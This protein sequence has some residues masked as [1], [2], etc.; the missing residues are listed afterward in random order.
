MKQWFYVFSIIVLALFAMGE[1]EMCKHSLKCNMVHIYEETPNAANT[2]GEMF[3]QGLYYGR[4]R[5]NSFGFRWQEEI[6][7]ERKDHAIVGLG[8]SMVFKSGYLHG[9]GMTLGAY[10]TVAQGSLR[11][12][13]SYLNK[14]GKD[15]FSRYDL[16]TKDKKGYMV[17]AE[18]YLEYL[19]GDSSFKFGR[20][21]FESFLTKSND[22]KMVP[23]TFEGFS[24]KSRF[25]ENVVIKAAYFTKQKLRDHSSFHSVLAYGDDA[26]IPYDQYRHNDDSAMH[27][28]LTTS[29][30][31]A[32]GIQDRLLV[33]EMMHRGMEHLTL[34]FNYTSV[35]HL[36]S[37]AMVQAD[38][39][40]DIGEW[41]VI[42]ALRYMKQFDDGAGAI[43]G[44]N[45]KRLNTGYVDATSLQSTLYAARVDMVHDALKLRV[46]YTS[47]ADEGDIVAPW[48]GFPTGGF[49]RAMGQYNWNANTKSLM[50]QL[51]YEF[52]AF[53]DLKL[54]SRY[55][56]Q[57]FDDNKAG[58]QADSNVFTIDFAKKMLDHRLYVKTRYAHVSGQPGKALESGFVK[59]DPSY[60]ELRIEI[61]YLF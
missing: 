35:P 46:G 45:L 37:S 7:K 25:A 21:I 36:I 11:I 19:H 15:A 39:R 24:V 17:L 10:G 48:R 47:V 29:K 55:V 18:G 23:N 5:M 61:N 56:I 49:T 54:I 3:T 22:T 58:V 57:D 20:Q 4:L 43:G 14:G 8:G 26:E 12:D 16:L 53:E 27:T 60:D 52:E 6:D 13:E 44:A 51:D 42:P 28:G 31:E 32:A 9:M 38:Y 50:L 40:M 59:L 2:L 33:F 34:Q 1:D 30:L 41:S